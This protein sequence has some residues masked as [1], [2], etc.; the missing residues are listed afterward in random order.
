MNVSSHQCGKRLYMIS[1]FKF[2]RLFFI[3][4]VNNGFG[5]GNYRFGILIIFVDSFNPSGC[6]RHLNLKYTLNLSTS[7]YE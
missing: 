5:V 7:S 4:D 2:S 3:K 6:C 1:D